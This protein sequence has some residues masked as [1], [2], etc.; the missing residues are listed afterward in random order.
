MLSR[1]ALGAVFPEATPAEKGRFWLLWAKR[2]IRRRYCPTVLG[3]DVRRR[4]E[5]LLRNGLHEAKR[6]AVAQLNV[7][8]LGHEEVCNVSVMWLWLSEVTDRFPGSSVPE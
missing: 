3:K 7:C 1:T 6:Q 4:C 5:H 8:D 2:L